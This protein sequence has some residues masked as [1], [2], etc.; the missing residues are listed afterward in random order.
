MCGSRS[1]WRSQLQ[2][3][4][5]G[6][7]FRPLTAVSRAGRSSPSGRRRR[8]LKSRERSQPPL[9]WPRTTDSLCP[10]CVRETRTRILSGEQAI[11]IAGQPARRRDPGAHLRAR[12]QGRDREDLPDA[13]HVHRHARDQPGVPRAASSRCFPGRDF[14]AV[15]DRLHNHGTSSIKHGRGAV[16]TIDLTNRCNMMCDPVLHGRQP[17]RLRPRADARRGQAAARR[18]GQHQAAPADDGAVLRRRADDLADLPRRGPLRARG[19]LLQ[20]AGGDQR[21]PL[22]AG[23]RSSPA[24][25]ARPACASP[26]CSSTA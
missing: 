24:R 15:T 16:L 17:G 18:R 5:R 4:S 25:R 20:R 19:R 21:H 13:R 22:R 8:S 1:S 11:D 12:R 14:D 7:H 6:R 2:R 26:T 10:T 9:G 23:C 3:N